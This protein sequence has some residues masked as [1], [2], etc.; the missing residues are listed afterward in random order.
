MIRSSTSLCLA[1][2]NCSML[3]LM[4]M[5]MVIFIVMMVIVTVMV[6]VKLEEKIDKQAPP[7]LYTKMSCSSDSSIDSTSAI[8]LIV[9]VSSV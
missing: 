2:L 8:K 6:M 7:F 1:D 9:S 3:M 4:V 5:L